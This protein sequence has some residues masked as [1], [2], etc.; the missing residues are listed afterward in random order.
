MK[1]NDQE[2]LNGLKFELQFLEHG[3]YERS[4]REPRRELSVFQDSP[5]CLNYASP[6]RKHPCSECLLINFVPPDKRG[7]SIP[8]HH[9]P[10]NECGDT[11]EKMQGYGRDFEVE[12]ATREWLKK[13]IAELEMELAVKPA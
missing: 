10:L 11:L 7:E 8:C 9:I 3:G 12:S 2:L 6:E 13:T 4:V 5:L 1:P